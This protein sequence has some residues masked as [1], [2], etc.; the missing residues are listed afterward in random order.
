MKDPTFHTRK[1]FSFFLLILISM[2]I[3][4]SLGSS[5]SGNAAPLKTIQEAQ[6]AVDNAWEVYHD[7]ALSGTLA[8]PE[9]QNQ[10]ESDLGKVRS[11]LTQARDAEKSE[12][13][14]LDDLLKK[15]ETLTQKI[16]AASRKEKP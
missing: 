6:E 3:V 13:R 2:V 10:I 12:P 7:A 16:V 8:S 4:I 5:T 9:I 15:I 1:Q 11:L 14:R